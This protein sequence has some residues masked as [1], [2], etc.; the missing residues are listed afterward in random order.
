MRSVL[1]IRFSALGDLVLTLPSLE[2]LAAQGDELHLL[3]KKSFLPILSTY[4]RPV[5][6]HTIT[7]SDD[8]IKIVELNVP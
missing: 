2:H 6:I 5:T 7:D 4:G 8:S 1:A 3:T